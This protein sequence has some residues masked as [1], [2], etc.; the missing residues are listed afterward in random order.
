MTREADIS[1]WDWIAAGFVL[2]IALVMIALVIGGGVLMVT[3]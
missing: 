1:R 2:T 3:R